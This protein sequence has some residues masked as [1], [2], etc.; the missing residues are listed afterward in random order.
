VIRTEKY[1]YLGGYTKVDSKLNFLGKP[2]LTQTY[3]K[4]TANDDEVVVID[5]FQYSDQERLLVHKQK[6][7]SL[8]E[9]LISKNTYNELGQLQSKQVGG[10]DVTTFVG[11]QKVDYQYNIRGWLKSINTI[12]NL[13]EQGNPDDLFAFKINY[14]EL[15]NNPAAAPVDALFNGNIA[16]TFWRTKSDNVVRKYGYQYDGL[17]RLN[18]AI[19]QKPDAT[20][21]V[22]NMYNEEMDY[23]KNGN[24]Q[25]LKRNGD[26]DDPTGTEAVQIDDLV[27][28]YDQYKKIS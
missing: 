24:I 15:D 4:R 17:N 8:P 5:M 7:N 28:S 21:Y 20:Y 11:L 23:D 2:E 10:E 3:H 19:Y 9:Q 6:I 27:Y 16:E 18:K 13:S 14:N 12:D 1:N 26:L 22:T 25:D